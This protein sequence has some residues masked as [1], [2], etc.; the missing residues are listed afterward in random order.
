MYAYMDV[1]MYVCMYVCMCVCMY[2][3]KWCVDSYDIR[4]HTDACMSGGEE[5]GV[6]LC[7]MT[8]IKY[9]NTRVCKECLTSDWS[10][11]AWAMRDAVV[12]VN[13]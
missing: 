4:T 2:V 8:C 7:V 13:Q 11:P 9:H 6:S 5:A 10:G 12:C 3:C 1:C